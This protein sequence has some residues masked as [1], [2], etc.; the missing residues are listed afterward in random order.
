MK[1]MTWEQHNISDGFV[2]V[3]MVPD[4]YLDTYRAAHSEMNKTAMRLQSGEMLELC[5]SCTALG[6]CMMKGVEQEYVQTSNGDVWIVTSTSPEV[7]AELQA[8]VKRN[9][10]EMAKVKSTKG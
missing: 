6:M 2:S 10:E 4:E 7:V 1:N 8:W 3:T 9:A 5:G